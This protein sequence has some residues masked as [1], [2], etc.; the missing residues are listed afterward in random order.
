MITV[1]ALA[2][3]AAA[4]AAS[5]PGSTSGAPSAAG[6]SVEWESPTFFVDGLG[7]SVTLEMYA[8]AEGA[9]LPAWALTPAG[10]ELN[11]RPLLERTG[12]TLTLAPNQRL[13]F[14]FDLGPYIAQA[15]GFAESAFTLKY[16]YPEEGTPM[17]VQYGQAAEQGLDFMKLPV[18]QLTDYLV[19]L[20]TNRGDMLCEFWPDVAPNHVRNFLDLAYTG[21]YDDTVFHRVIP[22][23]MIQGGDPTGT[24]TGS[25]KRK[26]TAEF[27]DRRHVPGVLSMAR[28]P[29][30]DSASCQ[31]F[32]M[33]GNAEHL[34]GQYS[35]FGKLVSGLEV[36]EKIVNTPSSRSNNRPNDKQKLLKAVVLKR[37]ADAGGE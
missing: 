15:P 19:L 16:A 35:A 27:N 9:Q 32:V 25:G 24:G 13:S 17:D 1:S 2:V 7:F 20:S 23:F 8:P 21:F 30:P 33:H 3:L 36:V 31:F 37:S 26:L 34:D 29:S 14:S 18:E 6:L 5:A 22:G 28:G 10:F 11:G 4:C 12:S